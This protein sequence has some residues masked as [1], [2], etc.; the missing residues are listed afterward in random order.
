LPG[1]PKDGKETSKKGKVGI[2][3]TKIIEEKKN[4]ERMKQ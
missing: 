2:D 1:I 3:Y 4:S